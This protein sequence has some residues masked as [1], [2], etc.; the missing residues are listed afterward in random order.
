M[1][2]LKSSDGNAICYIYTTSFVDDVTFSHNG[3]NGSESKT[4]CMFRLFRQVAVSGCTGA[5]CAVRVT[6]TPKKK[7]KKETIQ[8]HTAYSPMQI[9]HVV[10]S[11]SNFAWG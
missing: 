5:T 9:I 1:A 7:N 4:T 2:G 11:K 8:W 10:E 6:K 3:A